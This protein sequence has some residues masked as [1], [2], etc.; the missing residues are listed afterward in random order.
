MLVRRFQ[1]T[2]YMPT[3]IFARMFCAD[4][5]SLLSCLLSATIQRGIVRVGFID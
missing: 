1:P 3:G 2:G 5:P 4:F